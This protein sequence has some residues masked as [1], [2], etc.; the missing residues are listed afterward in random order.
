MKKISLILLLITAA[1]NTSAPM[2][3]S[4]TAAKINPA[5]AV[6]NAKLQAKPILFFDTSEFYVEREA[7]ITYPGSVIR[8]SKSVEMNEIEE[9][10]ENEMKDFM[11]KSQQIGADSQKLCDE[12][13]ASNRQQNM[14]REKLMKKLRAIKEAIAKRLNGCA[15]LEYNAPSS[16]IIVVDPAYDITQEVFDTLNKEYQDS[17]SKK[18]TCKHSCDVHCPTKCNTHCPH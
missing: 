17:Q 1:F 11:L 16:S 5:I 10:M 14:K 6:A 3:K 13:N 7:S 2:A 15:V 9:A 8:A 12:A 4:K 18:P